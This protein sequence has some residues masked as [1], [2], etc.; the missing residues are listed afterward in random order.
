MATAV[1]EAEIITGLM[2]D[3]RYRTWGHMHMV[4]DVLTRL[5]E[6]VDDAHLQQKVTYTGIMQLYADLLDVVLAGDFSRQDPRGYLREN[7]TRM[8]YSYL[9]LVEAHGPDFDA[10]EPIQND[11]FQFIP[12][13]RRMYDR[14]KLTFADL[15]RLQ[16]GIFVPSL[17][18]QRDLFLPGY[19]PID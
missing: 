18:P 8:R 14:G 6:F 11:S 9:S 15:L 2:A 19:E 7:L 1:T 5:P 10:R 3:P 4:T 17:N 13:V 12:S 16:P